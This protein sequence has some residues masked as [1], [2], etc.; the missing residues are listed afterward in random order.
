MTDTDVL[1]MLVC[2][3]LVL[4]MQAGFLLLETGLTRA[5][6]YIN[7]AVKNLS[8]LAF[9]VLLF[10]LFGWALMY[11]DSVGGVVG[12]SQFAVDLSSAPLDLSASFLFQVVF[13]GTTVTILSGTIAERTAF[14]GYVGIVAVMAVVY[15]VFG[16]WAWSSEGWLVNRGFS[17]SRDR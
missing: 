13:A 2:T 3:G 1:W 6:N 7:V 5:K 9:A 16:H 4:F 12:F 8:D 11:G 15:P 17:T 10:W 14:G